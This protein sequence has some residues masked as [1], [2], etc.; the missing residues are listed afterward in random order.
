MTTGVL[1]GSFL[2]YDMLKRD[3][4]LYPSYPHG[5]VIHLALGFIAAVIGAVAIP[6]LVEKEF[7][8]V[9][10]L[11]LAATQFREVRN[12]ERE[13]LQNLDRTNLVPRGP[14]YIEGIARVFEA[15]NYL[16]MFAALLVGGVTYWS[17]IFYGLISGLAALVVTRRL[18]KGK[19][20][21][22]IA[23]VREGKVHFKGPNLFVDNIHFMNLGID[24]VRDIYLERALGVIIEPLDDN[25]RAT[26]ANSGQRRAIAHD[27]AAL[28]GI[29]KDVDTPEFT[30]LVRRSLD[31][32][33]VGLVIVPLEKD[34][35]VLIEAVKRVPVLESALSTPL[36]TTLGKRAAD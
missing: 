17:N 34:I 24:K 35:S 18:M 15:R 22:D 36:K 2:R 8:A 32:G 21:G 23:K 14:D 13:M 25:G 4:R 16:V 20:I 1:I 28:L 3:Y 5:V 29:H 33:R 30:P 9:T 26:L 6:A 31:T 19:T 7:T 10:F 27:A 11:A 12:M